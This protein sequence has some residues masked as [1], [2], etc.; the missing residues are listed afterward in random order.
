[1]VY[2]GTDLARFGLKPNNHIAQD[3]YSR[4]Y[5]RNLHRNAIGLMTLSENLFYMV[6]FNMHRM[7]DNRSKT[8]PQFYKSSSWEHPLI[9]VFGETMDVMAGQAIAALTNHGINNENFLQVSRA[10]EER[11]RYIAGSYAASMLNFLEFNQSMQNEQLN[12]MFSC[13]FF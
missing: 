9:R 5:G 13:I 3:K 10:M 4:N 2:K 11:D 1:M 6:K 12:S 8:G 7:T